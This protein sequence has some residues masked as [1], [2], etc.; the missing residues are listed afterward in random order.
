MDS[1]GDGFEVVNTESVGVVI[2]IPANNVEWVRCRSDCVQVLL[3]SHLHNEFSFLIERFKIS[4]L[5]DIPFAERGVFKQ[6][7]E[8]VTVPF[9]CN[10]RGV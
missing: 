3:L 9:G 6:L 5:A 2:S 4:R 10:N 1:T 8:V 7:A